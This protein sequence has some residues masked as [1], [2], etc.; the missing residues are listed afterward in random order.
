MGPVLV[1]PDEVVQQLVVEG[2]QVFKEQ[3]F[4]AID[5]LLLNGA[6]E[7]LGVGVHLGALGVGEPAHSAVIEHDFGELGLEL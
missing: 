2:M 6:I 7:S 5:E 4:V 1:E 3:V